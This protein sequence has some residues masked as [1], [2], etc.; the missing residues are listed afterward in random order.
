MYTYTTLYS[1]VPSHL[2]ILDCVFFVTVKER[3]D[4]TNERAGRLGVHVANK[5]KKTSSGET[6]GEEEKEKRKSYV[7]ESKTRY[8]V[9]RRVDVVIVT[10]CQKYTGC[11]VKMR[12]VVVTTRPR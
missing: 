8:N 1:V 11:H 12:R 3:K 9:S 5:A 2:D 6:E 7:W 10:A 4:G